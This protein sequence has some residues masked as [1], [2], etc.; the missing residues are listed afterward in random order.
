[1]E[2][3][4]L[5]YADSLTEANAWLDSLKAKGA[6]PEYFKAEEAP[7][8]NGAYVYYGDQFDSVLVDPGEK[9]TVGSLSLEGTDYSFV[10]FE[11]CIEGRPEVIVV[12][13]ETGTKAS[14]SNEVDSKIT[15]LLRPELVKEYPGYIVGGN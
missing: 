6:I 9:F 1:M 15:D 2:I 3:H 12:P 4:T 11:Y 10:T 5:E 14:V 8:S 7:F 13:V